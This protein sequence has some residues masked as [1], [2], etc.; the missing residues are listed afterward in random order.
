MPPSTSSGPFIAVAGRRTAA[1][2]VGVAGEDAAGAPADRRV[3]AYE[4]SGRAVVE[5]C[6][7]LLALW[8]GAPSRGRGGTAEIVA[9]ARERG[10][11]AVVVPVRRAQE[12]ERPPRG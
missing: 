1:S 12:V 7:V 8:D 9:F 4:A 2:R 11:E 3:A 6:E 10:R 5:G